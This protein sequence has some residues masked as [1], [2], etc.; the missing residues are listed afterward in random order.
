MEFI[1]GGIADEE[2]NTQTIV[3]ILTEQKI[4]KVVYIYFTSKV[5]CGEHI[6]ILFAY[7]IF[8]LDEVGVQDFH[9]A[10]QQYVIK[11][12]N[13][14]KPTASYSVERNGKR[15]TALA[16]ITTNAD[17]ILP[18]IIINRTTHDSKLYKKINS[19]KFR[20]K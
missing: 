20:C 17:W 1:S 6:T 9:D 5:I 8:N 18:L 10:P 4:C 19:R 14:N 3:L 16:C 15:I 7:F 13:Y 12:R 11:R 2:K